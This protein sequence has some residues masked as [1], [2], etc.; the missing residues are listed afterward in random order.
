MR[1]IISVVIVVAAFFFAI[2]WFTNRNKDTSKLEYDTNLIQQQ[3]ANV[4]KLVVT[5][6]HFAQVITYRDRNKYLMDLV[7]F[8]KKALVVVNADV[9]VSYDLH[10]IKYDV[11]YKSKTITLLNIPKEE[12]KIDPQLTFY[13]VDQT[14]LSPFTGD[15]YNKINKKIRADL[16][17][18]IENSSLKSNAK[19]RL[20]S[21][22]SKML[23]LTNSMGWIL[24]YNN[25]EIKSE[26]DLTRQI[27][28]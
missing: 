27:K 8:E 21:E 28:S 10:Q 13:D 17:A 6:G 2:Y 26:A 5:E 20:V 7:S 18:K 15:D 11:D 24:R 23:I 16:E 12:I 9:S 1:R 3:I 4:G 22:I 25:S 14:S 19:N